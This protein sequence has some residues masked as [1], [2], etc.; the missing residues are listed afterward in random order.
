MLLS[1]YTFKKERKKGAS[2]TRTPG[3]R[4]GVNT[5]CVRLPM[6]ESWRGSWLPPP[7]RRKGKERGSPQ[8]HALF[9][10]FLSSRVHAD[11]YTGTLLQLKVTKWN[12]AAIFLWRRGAYKFTSSKVSLASAIH[13]TMQPHQSESIRNYSPSKLHWKA[14]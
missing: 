13:Q 3:C 8:A 7:Q 11:R 14:L 1:N 12:I 2:G 4:Y 5:L 10:D 9:G 6:P